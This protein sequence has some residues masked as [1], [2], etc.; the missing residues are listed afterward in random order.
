MLDLPELFAPA[1]NVRGRTWM[2]CSSE[3]DL[4]PQL[5]SSKSRMA[6]ETIAWSFHST[7]T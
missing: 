5:K 4:K 6:S 7:S 1:S 2:S 3:I